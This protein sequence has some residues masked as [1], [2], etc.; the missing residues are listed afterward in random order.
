MAGAASPSPA[1]RRYPE[2][3]SGLCLR[4]DVPMIHCVEA[5][6]E[7]DLATGARVQAVWADETVGYI[8]DIRCFELV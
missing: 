8:T 7:G 5:A 1:A 4:A 3:L 2:W 6:A